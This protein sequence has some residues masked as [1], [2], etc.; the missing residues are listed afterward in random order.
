MMS[1]RERATASGFAIDRRPDARAASAARHLG[2][3]GRDR[4]RLHREDR[5]R[6]RAGLAIERIDQDRADRDQRNEQRDG[7]ERAAPE[8]A[9]Q[10]A[11]QAPVMSRIR[12][13]RSQLARSG[14]FSHPDFCRHARRLG[15][16]QTL[17]L[18]RTRSA[19]LFRNRSAGAP[20]RAV[21]TPTRLRI[22]SSP[23]C[24]STSPLTIESPS[25]V[26]SWLPVI[27]GA[28]LEERIADVSAGRP[29]RCRRRCPPRRASMNPPSTSPVTTTLPPRRRELDG[30]GEQVDQDLLDGALVGDDVG[31]ISRHAADQVDAGLA[32][33][34]RH[35]VAAAVPITGAGVERLRRDLEVATLD[36][37]HVENAVDH[38]QQVMAGLADQASHI[39]AGASG[40]A[41][42][43]PRSPASRRTR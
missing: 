24:S 10:Q 36:L 29:R 17:D 14:T 22:A 31:K 5:R 19:A 6:M 9:A 25:P 38:R 40:R 23:P 3:L 8:R 15:D 43:S 12:R 39:R 21:P 26:P 20:D 16:R 27:G 37:R 30:V 28:H 2:R 11:A 33:A 18:R 13:N 4:A 32:R 42:S 34:Q 1:A 41:A 35:Q 7:V